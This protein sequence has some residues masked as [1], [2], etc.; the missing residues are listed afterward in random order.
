M[1]SWL[2][3][4]SK[5][6]FVAAPIS[7]RVAALPVVILSLFN[8]GTDPVVC[9]LLPLLLG[10]RNRSLAWQTR[11]NLPERALSAIL[12]LILIPA[13][14]SGGSFYKKKKRN[15]KKTLFFS[16]LMQKFRPSLWFV[17][18][19]DVFLVRC[20]SPLSSR[21]LLGWTYVHVAFYEF[22]GFCFCFFSLF[23]FGFTPHFKA[24]AVND[25]STPLSL[26][27]EGQ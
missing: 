12:P 25:V 19:P 14:D 16:H 21:A 11:N 18:R 20:R 24:T 13:A 5:P 2:S 10:N 15:G 4:A 9:F 27:C 1:P 8:A 26:T 17:F 6:L 7:C 22:P 23:W 3:Q